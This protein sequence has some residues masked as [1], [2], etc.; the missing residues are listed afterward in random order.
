MIR[1]SCRPDHAGGREGPV[2]AVSDIT[3]LRYESLNQSPY[4]GAKLLRGGF[5]SHSFKTDEVERGSRNYELNGSPGEGPGHD[6][7][8]PCHRPNPQEPTGWGAGFRA[9]PF[10]GRPQTDFGEVR[11]SRWSLFA[12]VD[13]RRRGAATLDRGAD[14]KVGSVEVPVW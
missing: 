2:P 8:G 14:G 6:R 7:A 3:F 10:S 13:D 5:D 9:S 4:H 1:P 12:S 11:R